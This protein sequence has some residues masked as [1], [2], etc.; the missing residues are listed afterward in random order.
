MELYSLKTINDI[1]KRFGFH[2]AKSLGQNFL[3]DKAVID[4]IIDATDI[5][6]EDLIIEIG[7]GI[8]VLTVEA[9]K[10]A[11]KVCAI[12]I[13]KNL[14]PV[15]DFTLR[16]YENIEVINQ[17]VLKTN[18]NQIIDSSNFGHVKLIG[19][20]PYYITTPIIMYLLENKI[21]I[22]SITIMMQKEVAERIMASPGSRTFGA[23]SLAVQ[24]YCEVEQVAEVPKEVF[25]P[26]PKVDSA[27]LKLSIRD[28]KPVHP[29][30]EKLMFRCIKAGFAQRRKTISNSLT[31]VGFSKDEIRLALEN[32]GINQTRRAE[33]L[34][35]EEFS[36]ISDE[37]AV[38]MENKNE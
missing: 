21:N 37:L 4:S 17:D 20:L 32:L 6:D 34:S 7:P 13:D 38:F 22:E 36:A 23:I 15:L 2:N 29:K 25:S 33:T 18:L 27:V 28:E 12:E 5:T 35:I 30:D 19:N 24:Y 10:Y 16:G 26:I 3:T 1:R 8:G 9:A 31:G 11:G 14:L